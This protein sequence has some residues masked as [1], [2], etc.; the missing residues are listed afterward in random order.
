MLFT[1]PKR[2]TSSSVSA[3]LFDL[4]CHLAGFS[5]YNG[6]CRRALNKSNIRQCVDNRPI[7]IHT[8]LNPFLIL[9][10]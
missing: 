9:T 3:L 1:A 5:A 4:E 6:L 10:S 2:N 7:S 8:H